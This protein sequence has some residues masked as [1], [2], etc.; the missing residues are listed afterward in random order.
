MARW[1]RRKQI[2]LQP[3]QCHNIRNQNRVQ[4][5]GAGEGEAVTKR[6]MGY[7][8]CS[9]QTGFETVVDDRRIKSSHM[10]QLIHKKK[11]GKQGVANRSS[12]LLLKN[13]T[14]ESN[15]TYGGGVRR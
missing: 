9:Q 10:L 6:V 15:A 7:Q 11:W 5:V 3:G 14:N 8:N 2:S 1:R 12:E 4:K 13:Q